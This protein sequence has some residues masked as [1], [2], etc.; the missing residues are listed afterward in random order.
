M[1]SVRYLPI[2]V[3]FVYGYRLSQASDDPV[4]IFLSHI[5]NATNNLWVQLETDDDHV[6]LRSD[7]ESFIHSYDTDNNTHVT[8]LEFYT[9]FLKDD[10]DLGSIAYGLF[11]EFD[12][13]QDGV[14]DS[15][16]LD[17]IYARI[18]INNDLRVDET[19]FKQYFKSLLTVLFLIHIQGIP[20]PGPIV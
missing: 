6:F 7:L 17:T 16:D 11:L 10:P 3:L 5:D 13:N 19:E 4:Q 14:I 15:K 1:F 9:H 2:F 18:D 12:S 8:R 20:E